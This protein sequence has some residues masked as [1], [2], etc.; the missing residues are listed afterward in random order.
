MTV[1]YRGVE[2]V[3]VTLV[4]DETYHA[5]IRKLIVES[6]VAF[7]ASIFIVEIAPERD[8]N[9]LV[10]GVLTLLQAARWRGVDV[11]LLI[12]GSR[13]NLKIAELSLTAETI[14]KRYD[15]PA[16]W[17]TKGEV[18]GSHVKL[19]IADDRSLVGSHNWSPGAFSGQVQDS[20]LVKDRGL[21]SYLRTRFLDQWERI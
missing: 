13:N 4:P 17:I 12:G 15:I 8:R 7:Y 14:A 11:R 18:Q 9:F 10:D 19:A 6:Q 5:V 16:K 1:A 2:N 20:V 21:A 3:Q